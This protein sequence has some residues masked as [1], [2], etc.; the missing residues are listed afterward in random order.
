[1]TV[2]R[3]KPTTTNDELSPLSIA[4][5]AIEARDDE[6][7]L[8]G[9]ER[10]IDNELERVSSPLPRIHDDD[11]GIGLTSQSDALELLQYLS[12]LEET[13][14]DVEEETP[15][16]GGCGDRTTPAV[17]RRGAR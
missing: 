2:G 9:R 5:F 15:R 3:L 13:R 1:M 6:Y 8:A 14:D 11:D 7:D 4:E 17:T 12:Q 10:E 16:D